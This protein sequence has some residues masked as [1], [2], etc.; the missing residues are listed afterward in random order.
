ME[1]W[2]QCET[3]ASSHH[4][5]RCGMIVRCAPDL[6]NSLMEASSV[7]SERVQKVFC[8]SANT[9]M[10]ILPLACRA[11]SA[12]RS[13][14]IRNAGRYFHDRTRKRVIETNAKCLSGCIAGV[15]S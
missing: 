15:H 9:P 10:A 1:S 8:T 7:H 2:L 12:E 11:C 5:S 14:A 4:S 13:A 3:D 6:M